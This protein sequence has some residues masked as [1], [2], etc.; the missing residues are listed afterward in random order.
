M[1]LT[2]LTEIKTIIHSYPA[3]NFFDREVN[4]ALK[5]GFELQDAIDIDVDNAQL[6]AILVK[7]A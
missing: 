7:F 4:Q 5:D 2:K 1:S 3:S 6:V